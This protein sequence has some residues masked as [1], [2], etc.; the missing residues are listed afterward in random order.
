MRRLPID[1]L[2]PCMR[3]ARAVYSASGQLLVNTGTKLTPGIIERLRAM[4][5]P[6]LYVEDSRGCDV[7]VE[8]VISQETRSKAVRQVKELLEEEGNGQAGSVRAIIQVRELA[9]TVE[10][11][12]EELLAKKDLVVNLT[13][14]RA[15]DDYTF[16][17]SVNVCVLSLL[18]GISMSYSRDELLHLGLGA[19]MHDL[20]KTKVPPAILQ[21]P[22]PLTPEEFDIIRQ[23]PEW[24]YRLIQALNE[25]S[26]Q[27]AV[28]PLQHH[29][30]FA[31]QGYP[32]GL[33]GKEI[34]PFGA[35]CGVADVFDA[36]TADRVY[37][38]A[39]PV[40]EAFELI[41]GSG[42]HLFA[43]PVVRAF[44]ENVA[45]Y[46]TGTL[47]RLSSGE[48]GVTIKTLRGMAL[49]PVVRVLYDAAGAAV[50]PYEVSL[51][52]RRDVVI[53]GAV[54]TGS[55]SSPAHTSS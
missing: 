41:A 54:V 16:G 22:A 8:D 9:K 44:L 14:I 39:A 10:E 4:G 40:H 53:T 23:H 13:D 18:T 43:Y 17:H 30:R 38:K 19:I 50:E 45:A 3:V 2:K 24:G 55:A 51:A 6:A 1:N 12:I 35:I 52:E 29:E 46:P 48:T 5:I 33:Q 20:G 26:S 28:V 25:V 21:K 34:H 49:R 37:K 11:I 31:G 7:P 27:A 42:N 36:L 32:K 47:V 15:L